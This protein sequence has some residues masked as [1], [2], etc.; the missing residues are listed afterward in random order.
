MDNGQTFDFVIKKGQIG[1]NPMDKS[2]LPSGI[3]FDEMSNIKLNDK[4]NQL[5]TRL[6]KLEE[7]QIDCTIS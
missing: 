1:G 5:N 4:I 2:K 6:N 7:T 3:N